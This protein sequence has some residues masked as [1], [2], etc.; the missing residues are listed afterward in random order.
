MKDKRFIYYGNPCTVGLTDPEVRSFAEAQRR[1]PKPCAF[2]DEG[3]KCSLAGLGCVAVAGA[4]MARCVL[5]FYTQASEETLA[6]D[7]DFFRRR[8]ALPPKDV[9]AYIDTA[10]HGYRRITDPELVVQRVWEYA[11]AVL[12]FKNGERVAREPG[13]FVPPGEEVPAVFQRESGNGRPKSRVRSERVSGERVRSENGQQMAGNGYSV[14]GYEF[15]Q[16]IAAEAGGECVLWCAQCGSCS[17][18]CPNV[19]WM[20][21][22]PRKIIALARAGKREEVL[23]SNSMWCCATCHLCTVR[24]PKGVEVPELMHVLESMAS[25]EGLA[26]RGVSTPAMYKVLIDAMRRQG[27]VHE[28]GVMRSFFLRTNP[29]AALKMAPV[30]L[31]LLLHGRLPLR[32]EKI[33]GTDQLKAIVK[34]VKKE[35]ETIGG[36]K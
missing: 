28:L 36:P 12:S 7:R 4:L 29:L 20:Q 15:V 2:L 33:Q 14:D 30:G 5:Q 8:A 17:G 34:A 23:G 10:E 19:L 13:R 31:K 21:Y 22:S 1:G 16:E 11:R 32:A 3:G 18:S 25:R 27:R 6:L 26:S 24:C 9:E 35:A